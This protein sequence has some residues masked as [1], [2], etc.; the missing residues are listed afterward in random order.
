MGRAPWLTR[1]PVTRYGLP[2]EASVARPRFDSEYPVEQALSDELANLIA[3]RFIARRDV[4]AIQHPD[5]SW[6]PH[7][8]SGKRDGERIPW[9]RSDLLAHLAGD[10]TFGHY[11]LDTDSTCKLFAFDVDLE[12]NKYMADGTS[13]PVPIWEGALPST[14]LDRTAEDFDAEYERWRNSFVRTDAR[15]AW[16]DRKHIARAFMKEQFRSIAHLLASAITRELEIPCAAAYSGG[17]GIHVYGFTGKVSA[18]DAR[19][20]AM[21]VLDALGDFEAVRGNNFFRQKLSPDSATSFVDGYWNLSIEVFPKQDS[22]DGK[23]LGNLMRL[24]LGRN[25]K[26]ADPTFFIDLCSPMSELRPTD[27]VRALELGDPWRMP[28]E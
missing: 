7:T 1:G 28:G 3:S 20:G 22:L 10:K 18:A 11:M 4:K 12:K 19:E 24:P 8:K 9:T 15:D 14:A 21:I 2:P 6:S 5:G 25:L 23:D 16:Q 27:P 26:S 17:K 13:V